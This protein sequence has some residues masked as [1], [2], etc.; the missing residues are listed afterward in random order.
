MSAMLQVHV[1]VD[2]V[3]ATCS[4][5]QCSYAA[6]TAATPTITDVQMT[7]TGTGLNRSIAIFGSGFADDIL[8]NTVMV[9]EQV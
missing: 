1:E 9:A 3:G 2:S 5:E 4:P 6:T 8:G 7:S